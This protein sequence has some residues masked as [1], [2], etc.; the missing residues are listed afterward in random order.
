[1]VDRPEERLVALEKKIVTYDTY[2]K[3]AA[4]VAVIFGLASGWG[5]TAISSARSAIATI[6]SDSGNL[7]QKFTELTNISTKVI[8]VASL[9]EQAK[10][11]TSVSEELAGRDG[12]EIIDSD[13]K[14]TEGA[15]IS[16][17]VKLSSDGLVFISAFVTGARR[18]GGGVNAGVRA[19]IYL[20]DVPCSSD[21]SFEGTSSR[22]IFTSS[23]S[24]IKLFDTKNHI[25]KVERQDSD[26]I[27]ANQ[28]ISAEYIAVKV[29]K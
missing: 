4:I 1:M 9:A 18:G 22:V 10:I 20:D 21:Y 2:A 25:I 24:C 14:G 8:E 6:Q 11:A 13:S 5:Y 7:E 27:D 17:P 26:T 3:A 16:F 19:V 12:I 28:S 23:V 29:M 15:E